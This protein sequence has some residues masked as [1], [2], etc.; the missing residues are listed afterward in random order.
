MRIEVGYGL[1]GAISDTA[2]G[3]IRDR[4]LIPAFKKSDYDGGILKAYNALARRVMAEYKIKEAD[5]NLPAEIKG[6]V[7]K[8][9][10]SG[11][12]AKKENS[13]G[14]IALGLESL[15]YCWCFLCLLIRRFAKAMTGLF[16]AVTR[17]SKLSG[18]YKG[19]GN[20]RSYY[21]DDG[22]SHRSRY[23]GDDD[24]SSSSDN[25]SYGGGSGGG[26]G[27]SGEW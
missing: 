3:S 9:T 4:Y 22:H 15:S 23:H 24:S 17:R 1:E 20:R 19:G 13:P 6:N 27:A 21:H 7:E 25:D 18:R 5:L 14:M 16:K 26:G 8:S 10:S 11:G 2:A 12:K